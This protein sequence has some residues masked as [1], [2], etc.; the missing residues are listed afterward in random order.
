M[1]MKLRLLRRG[2]YSAGADVAELGGRV[3]WGWSLPSGG[4][5]NG[6]ADGGG[7]ARRGWWPDETSSASAGNTAH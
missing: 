6:G 4:W 1:E 2:C 5:R 7:W 3:P